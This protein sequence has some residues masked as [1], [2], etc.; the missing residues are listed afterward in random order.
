MCGIVGCVAREAPV[1]GALLGGL[2][3]LE[4]RGYDSAGVAVLEH[5]ELRIVREVGKLRRLEDV[6]QGAPLLG[7]TGIGHTRWATHGKPSER[8]AHPHQG[9]RGDVVAAHNGI[10]ENYRELR[11]RLVARGHVFLSETDSEVIPHL[12]EDYYRGDFPDAVRR[13]LLLHRKLDH[14]TTV[15]TT[16]H[17]AQR[18][19][20]GEFVERTS[21]AVAGR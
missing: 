2:K 13:A 7:R 9:G 1:V 14:S 20:V 18:S 6:L 21:T 3:R 19:D 5:G 11:D 12:I 16:V 8:N 17:E 4:Y 15:G 10:I